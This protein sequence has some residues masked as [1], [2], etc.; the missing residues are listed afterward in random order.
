LT[1]IPG[2]SFFAIQWEAESQEIA[3]LG[4]DVKDLWPTMKTLPFGDRGWSLLETA[5]FIAGMDLVITCDSV[6]AHVA[7]TMN[8]ATW[9]PLPLASE[10]RWGLNKKYGLWY[11]DNVK[12][13]H[14]QQYRDWAPVFDEMKEKLE[15][16]VASRQT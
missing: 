4:P 5:G 7:G 9:V 3:D 8:V 16:L 2:T 11:P 1:Q 10:W 12:L 13:F 14:Q 15:D 6:V